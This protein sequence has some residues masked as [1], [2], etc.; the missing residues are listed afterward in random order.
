VATKKATA[1]F[2]MLEEAPTEENVNNKIALDDLIPVM[3]LIDYPLNLLQQTTGRAKYRFDK[4][5][6][7]KQV[8][9][10]DL[11]SILE[12]YMHFLEAG[13]FI[14]LDKK[15]I[16]RHGLQ[17]MF[18]KILTKEQIEKILDGSKD[19]VKLYEGCSPEQQ[20]KVIG[21]VTRKLFASPDSVDMNI[22]NQLSRLSGINIM[23]NARDMTANSKQEDDES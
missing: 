7:T 8:L 12:N 6:Q 14:I 5:G 11:L 1:G 23:E 15:V 2:N 18:S 13:Y 10:Q 19:A 9:Y 20:R 4:F 21:M 3:S 22:V 17:D 16:G